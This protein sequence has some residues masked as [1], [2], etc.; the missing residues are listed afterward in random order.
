MLVAAAIGVDFGVQGNFVLG[1][2]SIFSLVAPDARARLNGVYLATFFA[3]GALGSAV[4]AWA[5][6]KG[7]WPL[8]SRIGLAL[9][10]IALARFVFRAAMGRGQPPK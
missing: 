1:L 10:L 3:A 9:P 6:A 5:F 2:R 8:A 4:G 7:G